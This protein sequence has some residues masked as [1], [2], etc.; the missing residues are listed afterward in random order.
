MLEY[1]S[2]IVSSVIDEEQECLDN[3]PENLTDSERYQKMEAAVEKLEE[4]AEQIG[5]A[6]DCIEEASV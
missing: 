1:A 6:I 2:D 3:M 5:A 4:A